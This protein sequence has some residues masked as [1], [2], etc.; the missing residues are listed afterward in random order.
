MHMVPIEAG[1]IESPLKLEF[2][3]LLADMGPGYRTWV[4]FKSRGVM[5]S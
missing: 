1:G 2:R 5:C 3:Q 4:R